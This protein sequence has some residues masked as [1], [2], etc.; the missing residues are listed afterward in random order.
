MI[1]SFFAS[2]FVTFQFSKW[3]TFFL[4]MMGRGGGACVLGI[5][6]SRKINRRLIEKSV[7]VP[8]QIMKTHHFFVCF[9]HHFEKCTSMLRPGSHPKKS[10]QPTRLG[11]IGFTAQH[12]DRIIEDILNLLF[13]I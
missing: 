12:I 6:S 8:K 10:Q 1:F 5:F 11:R 7:V 3:I 9:F 13:M 2:V 4:V